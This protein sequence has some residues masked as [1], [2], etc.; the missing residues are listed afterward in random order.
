LKPQ[1]QI[2]RSIPKALKR[3]DK[4]LYILF[5]SHSDMNE[6]LLPSSNPILL[7]NLD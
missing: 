7:R 1:G 3:V 2:S 6:M 5:Y 4:N